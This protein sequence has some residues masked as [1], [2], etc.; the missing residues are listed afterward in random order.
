M[1]SEGLVGL[2]SDEGFFRGSIS[3]GRMIWSAR[4]WSAMRI[5]G[6]RRALVASV[7][8]KMLSAAA[9]TAA[10]RHVHPESH[11]GPPFRSTHWG[12]YRDSTVSQTGCQ[13]QLVSLRA[14]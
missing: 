13:C 3:E 6:K 12:Y 14:P 5:G 8:A 7:A 1:M 11:C 9:A 10:K 2:D 4:Q